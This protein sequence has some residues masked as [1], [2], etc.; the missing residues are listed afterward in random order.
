MRAATDE[1]LIRDLT[2]TRVDL[3]DDKGICFIYFYTP[4]GEEAFKKDTLNVLIPYKPSLRKALAQLLHG[5]TVPD[6][7]FRFDTTFDKVMR[8]EKIIDSVSTG[9]SSHDS[10][11][12]APHADDDASRDTL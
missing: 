1:P 4:L 5:R 11:E 7:V 12:A 8:I 10:E 3:T 6:L 2:I 9:T